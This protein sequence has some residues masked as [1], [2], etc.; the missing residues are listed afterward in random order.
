MKKILSL[1]FSFLFI[2]LVAFTPGDRPTYI[3]IGW[4]DL[5]MHCANRNVQNFCILPP[6]NNQH[7]QV[8]KV[9]DATH[10]PEV[11]N[12]DIT[13]TYEIPG[14][15]YSVGKTDFWTYAFDLFGVTLPDN[16]GLTGNGLTGTMI[17]TENYYEATG[18][19]VTPYQDDNLTT[20]QPFQLALIKA[21]D[22]N[23]NLLCSTQPVIPVSN[24]INCVSSGCHSSETNILYSHEQEGGF[25]PTATPI[26]CA[27]CH[28]DNA[29]G[30]P[31][32][33]GV[34]VF[35]RAIHGTHA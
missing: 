27:D 34:P 26:L 31:G 2:V 5:G 30:T 10:L 13:V 9:G 14:N 28:A 32:V 19:P 20:E 25:D 35:S 23:N 8:V 7:A 15:T 29:L 17:Q 33:P 16:I 22:G 11:I 18:I 12:Y 1:V 6:Y 3:I 24:E 4:N 21:F